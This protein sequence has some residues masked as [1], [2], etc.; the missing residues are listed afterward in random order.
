MVSRKYT[1]PLKAKPEPETRLDIVT[2]IG[3]LQERRPGC[4]RFIQDWIDVEIKR[5]QGK[6]EELK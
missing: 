2:R 3:E 6:L 1:P 4:E 5:L